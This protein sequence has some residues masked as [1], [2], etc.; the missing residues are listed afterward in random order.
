MG[1]PLHLLAVLVICGFLAYLFDR[2]VPLEGRIRDVIYAIAGLLLFLYILSW[3]GLNLGRFGH[4]A[5]A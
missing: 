4:L 5:V 2:L 1:N 3:F